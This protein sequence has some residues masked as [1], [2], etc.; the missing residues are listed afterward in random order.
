MSAKMSLID[1]A[2][3]VV[4]AGFAPLAVAHAH[5][6]PE[7]TSVSPGATQAAA[8]PV[9]QPETSQN[10]STL[11]DDDGLTPLHRAAGRGDTEEVLRLL[12]AGADLWT[13]D[14]KMGVSVLH[15]AVYSGHLDTVELLL[16]RGALI[17]LQSPSNGNTP[18]HDAIYFQPGDDKQ[19]VEVLLKYGASL[20]TKNRAGLA[21]TESARVLHKDDLVALLEKTAME[22]QSI[23]SRQLMDAVQNN[24]E[25]KVK[26]IVATKK[27][28][29]RQC[30]DQG[31]TPLLWASRQGYCSIV[32]ILLQ[33]GAD[34]NQ[35][36]HWMHANSGHKAAFWGHA[37]VM[38]LLADNGLKLDTRGGYNGYTALHDAVSQ[39][40]ADVVRV[41]LTHGASVKIKGHDG[42]TA[43]DIAVANKNADIIKLLEQAA[44]QAK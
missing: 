31:F 25:A 15:K 30:D 33:H 8:S 43:L 2:T 38:Q 16:Q 28:D 7:A 39:N 37:D 11:R 14:A 20:S 22:R 42:K 9:P 27:V 32:N 17:D 1:V 5:F 35:Q 34:P 26:Q 4:I 3:A 29:L 19:I 6:E 36:D 12:D 44:A 41:L 23:G 10:L 40:H 18:L 24:D 13:L 21:P